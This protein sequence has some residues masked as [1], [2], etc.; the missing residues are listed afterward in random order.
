V[1]HQFGASHF[2]S[3]VASAVQCPIALLTQNGTQPSKK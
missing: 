2:D 1:A 3:S